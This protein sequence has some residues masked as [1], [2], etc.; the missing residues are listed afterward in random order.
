MN[1]S[2]RRIPTSFARPAASRLA[3]AL[4]AALVILCAYAAPSRAAVSTSFPN[5][6]FSDDFES[7][8]L[9]AWNGA[10]AQGN[11]SA[12]VTAAAAHA[13]TAGLNMT[14]AAGQ[15]AILVKSL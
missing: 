4:V 9:G 13:G 5:T 6:V 11:G 7:G 15:Y 1:S 2:F 12:T 8:L 14:N 10:G 3:C